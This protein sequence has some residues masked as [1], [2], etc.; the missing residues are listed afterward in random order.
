MGI[1]VEFVVKPIGEITQSSLCKNSANFFSNFFCSSLI[2]ISFAKP[3]MQLPLFF[4]V[5]M[6]KGVTI[7]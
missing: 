4:K 5:S 3:F 7:S 6:I 1:K 2:P